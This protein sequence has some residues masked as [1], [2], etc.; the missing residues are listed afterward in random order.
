MNIY[1]LAG[2]IIHLTTIVGLLLYIW[3]KGS[4]KGISGRTQIL[5]ALLF[6]ARYTDL[7]TNYISVYNSCMKIVFIA[8][9]YVTVLSIYFKYKESYNSQ[10][11]TFR[12]ETLII[13]ATV[14]AIFVHYKFTYFEVLWAFSEYL[15]AVAIIPQLYLVSKAGKSE[16]VVTYYIF[17]L[18]MYRS[19]YLINWLYRY[20]GENYYDLFSI[21]PAI[22][23][24]LIYFDYFF[25][26]LSS[27]LISK[28]QKTNTFA[29]D[30]EGKYPVFV[31]SYDAVPSSP[32]KTNPADKV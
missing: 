26:L 23:Q 16:K 5:F 7:F 3:R 25:A 4:C 9:T 14:I 1:R 6:T 8:V 32:Q 10:Y 31:L 28:Y 21:V 27:R 18:A 20:F 29:T 12:S 19:L 13:G 17:G 30:V 2:D 22:I 11:D 24:L 15:E